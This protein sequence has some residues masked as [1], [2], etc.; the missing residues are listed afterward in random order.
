MQR[1]NTYEL[2]VSK[3]KK[4]LLLEMM[5]LSS[6]VWNMANYD[7]RQNIINKKSVKSF[8]QYREML[9]K[10]DD[11]QK[12]GR[13]YAS[14]K[15]RK[16]SFNT[17]S[18]FGLIKSK[19]QKKVGLPMYL[20]NR[21]T[22]TTLPSSLYVDGV[23]YHFKGQKIFLPLSRV[24]RKET[25]L[26][27]LHFLFKNKPQYEGKQGMGELIFDKVKKKFYFHQSIEC[28]TP[29]KKKVEKIVAIDI[30]VKRGITAF[31]GENIYMY[32]NTIIEKYNDISKRISL[33]QEIAIKRNH[34]YTTKQITSL[35][36]KRKSIVQNYNKNI[37][38][39]FQKDVNPDKI[40]VG[41]VK[42]IR[43]NNDN[44]RKSNR[45]IHNLWSFDNYY[46]RQQCKAENTGTTLELVDESYT[47][48]TC[49]ICGEKNTSKDRKY[50]C[51]YC[52]YHQDRD[53]V[54]AI[55]IYKRYVSKDCNTNPMVKI[56][57]SFIPNYSNLGNENLI[58]D[59]GNG[60]EAHSL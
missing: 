37:I 1:T 22:N 31:D 47:S 51:K 52:S 56:Y 29:E 26:K 23:Q 32:P 19:T 18:F 46:K 41:D 12:L 16:Y 11:Y 25:G 21:K 54:G 14:P 10:K 24:M 49:P 60:Q 13:S 39:W 6:C 50:D 42:H 43:E 45:M 34:R 53:V 30:G 35:Y 5:I 2:E 3:S 7:F 20:K 59:M 9:Q 33:L 4:K 8:F 36:H 44:G 55:N 17:L 58:S 57:R 15:L 40:F 38:S 28:I 48:V 27:G